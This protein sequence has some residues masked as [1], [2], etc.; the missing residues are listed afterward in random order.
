MTLGTGE[1]RTV[2]FPWRTLLPDHSL[3]VLLVAEGWRFDRLEHG[4]L[5]LPRDWFRTPVPEFWSHD[6][7]GMA[8]PAWPPARNA[9][10][11]KDEPGG[12]KE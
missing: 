8:L 9:A 3:R 5:P 4:P 12:S 2:R 1:S 11:K 6:T 10:G 7:P